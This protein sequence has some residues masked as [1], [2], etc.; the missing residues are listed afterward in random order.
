MLDE[1]IFPVTDAKESGGGLPPLVPRVLLRLFAGP[2]EMRPSSTESNEDVVTDNLQRFTKPRLMRAAPRIISRSRKTAAKKRT[3]KEAGITPDIIEV[4]P[5]KTNGKSAKSN[6]VKRSL[7]PL[8][9][10]DLCKGVI[11][12]GGLMRVANTAPESAFI[13]VKPGT[14]ASRD[15]PVVS[16]RYG[17]RSELLSQF[18]KCAFNTLASLG[19]R[20]K[21]PGIADDIEAYPCFHCPDRIFLTAYG[22]E[23]HTRETHPEHL[24]EVLEEIVKITAE[25]QRRDTIVR[26]TP[27]PVIPTDASLT[28]EAC[29]IC[30]RL[31][32]VEHPTALDNHL[33]AHKKNDQ[34]R[35]H[36]VSV[37][38]EEH[39]LRLTCLDCHLV[40]PDDKK[41]SNHKQH[42]HIRKRKY[43]CK[44]CGTMCVS[45]TDLNMHKAEHHNL[46]ILRNSYDPL[47]LKLR[48]HF[49]TSALGQ[50]A[51][52]H[53]KSQNNESS[54]SNY[55]RVLQS[56][57]EAP[58]R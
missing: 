25:W 27:M 8:L 53:R 37:F 38:G 16:T 39:V 18:K 21:L 46:P 14:S 11:V 51:N 4:K 17:Y 41:L 2:P 7:D 55:E 13:N 22:L 42:M 52:P 6:G 57:D 49:V 29:R 1:S 33:R 44:W 56:S 30:G 12:Q 9:E 19:E 3:A 43:I 36:M 48:S 23:N 54:D 58:C 20:V 50:R 24:E 35:D 34:L 15:Y 45:M 40:F 28:F 5:V 10:D 32:N 47:P 26:R 31:V